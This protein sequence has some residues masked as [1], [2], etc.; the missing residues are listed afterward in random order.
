MSVHIGLMIWKQMKRQNLSNTGL[1]TSLGISRTRMQAILNEPS[2]NT[3]ILL[4][5][6]EIMKFNFFQY[7]EDNETFK[8]IKTQSQQEAIEEVKRLNALLLEKNKA[9]ELKDQLLKA[10]ANIILTLEKGQYI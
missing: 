1:A 2:V 3:D 10:Q 7:Y 8:K 9:I 6:S 5:I 4:N